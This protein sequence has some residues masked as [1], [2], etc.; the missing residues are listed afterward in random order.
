MNPLRQAVKSLLGRQA[1]PTEAAPAPSGYSTPEPRPPFPDAG[2][3]ARVV[4][5][6]ESWCSDSRKAERLCI[7]RGWPTHREDLQGR[8]AEK[9]ALFGTHHWRTLPM[10]VVDG[11]FIGGLKELKALDRLP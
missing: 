1:P 11:R 10:V 2:P 9:S 6:V 8:H 7:E 4:L 3:S 5:Y